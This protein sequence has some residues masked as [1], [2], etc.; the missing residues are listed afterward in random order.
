M[1]RRAFLRSAGQ[2]AA[3]LLAAR[4]P[5][6][7]AGP[8][9]AEHLDIAAAHLDELRRLDG[10]RG[11]IA[12]VVRATE[13]A[14]HLFRQLKST[15]ES[16][17]LRPRLA[18]LASEAASLAGWCAVNLGDP[19]TATAW[20]KVTE[21]SGEQGRHPDMHAWGIRQQ[22]KVLETVGRHDDA[23]AVLARARVHGVSASIRVEVETLRAL[24]AAKL[25]GRAKHVSWSL[26]AL[27]RA[28]E[29]ST[30]AGGPPSQLPWAWSITPSYVDVQRG[31]CS[32]ALGDG[33]AAY[34][35]LQV[36]LRQHPK[37]L[38]RGTG[39]IHLGLA[40]AAVLMGDVERAADHAR[41]AREVFSATRAARQTEELRRFR[42]VQLGPFADTRAVRDLD[43]ELRAG[44]RYK[45]C[46][47][48]DHKTRVHQSTCPY[49]RRGKARPWTFAGRL[50]PGD[51]A[52]AAA[53]AGYETCKRC[54]HGR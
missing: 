38:Y 35:L 18:L 43:D 14:D 5:T 6:A 32:V 27:D 40:S 47:T 15:P 51:A 9:G 39:E 45:L 53:E 17:K 1:E 49:A 11:A 20:F 16:A 30:E 33:H 22:A 26:R 2:S 13:R 48:E 36:G 28:S 12:V 31:H 21:A 4:F 8:L 50:N 7:D 37:E 44:A 52:I 34:R 23:L 42:E 25:R 29:A 46:E 3:Y 19:R 54:M 10:Q 41:R 24:A